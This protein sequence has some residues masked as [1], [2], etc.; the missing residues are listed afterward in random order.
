[1]AGFQKDVIAACS[2]P[3]VW[4]RLYVGSQPAEAELSAGF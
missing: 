3:L 2:Q 1:M 4:Q